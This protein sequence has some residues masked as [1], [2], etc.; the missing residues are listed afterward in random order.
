MFK[1]TALVV[2]IFKSRLIN[3]TEALA[4]EGREQNITANV[5]IPSIIDT[6]DNRKAMLD[7]KFDS[8]V[9]PEMIAETI[10]FLCSDAANEISGAVIPVYG[11]S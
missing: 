3:F 5:V 1:E 10:L 9:K 2:N 7:A 4:E 8:W 6:S 11:K